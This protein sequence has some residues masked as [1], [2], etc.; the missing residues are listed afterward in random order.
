MD[1]SLL[2]TKF[3]VPILSLGMVTRTGLLERL[4]D[5]VNYRLILVSA[6][7]GFGK[8]TLLSEWIHQI[9]PTI[10]VAWVSLDEGDNEPLRFW[11]YFIT[12]IN[13]IE[14]AVGET[15]LAFLHS[16]Q[17][18]SFES[19]LT[20]L[21]NDLTSIPGD[22]VLVLDDFHF[23]QS[24]AIHK[25]L[26]YFLEHMPPGMRLIISTRADPPLPI[27]RFRGKGTLLEIG[28]DDLRF[29]REETASLFVEMGIKPLSDLVIDAMNTKA[30]GWVAGLKMA[31]L[32]MRNKD[33]L[34]TFV[35]DFTGSQ[36]FITDY[37]FEEVLQQQSEEVCT[38]LLQTSILNRLSFPLCDAI[39]GRDDSEGMLSRLDNSNLF[40]IPLDDS[41]EWYR[42]HHLFR[43]LLQHQLM[44]GTKKEQIKN[45]H[46]KASR[47][48][49]DNNL[50]DDAI[51][52]ALAA[53]DWERAM[54]LI[55][56]PEVQARTTRSQVMLNWL[57]QIPVEVARTRA[58][59]CMNY[60][61]VLEGAGKYD[62]A[63]RWVTH[64]DEIAENDSY[65]Q[66][67]VAVARSVITYHK[68]DFIQAQEYAEK[69]LSLLTIDDTQK[70]MASA[71]LAGV[72]LSQQRYLEAEPLEKRFYEIFRQ[73]GYTVHAIGPLFWL[74]Y[75]AFL[76]GNFQ[77][78]V[79]NFQEVIEL[80]SEFPAMGN[81]ISNAYLMIGCAHYIWNN[82]GKAAYF[83]EKAIEVYQL[84][85]EY[86]SLNFDSVY[87]HLAVTRMAMGEIDKAMEAMEKADQLLN[88]QDSIHRARNTAFH[89]AIALS[90]GDTDSASR[91]IDALMDLV[92]FIPLDAP[93]STMHLIDIRKGKDAA[94]K[95]LDDKYNFYLSQDCK[96]V[97]VG[98]RIRQALISDKYEETLE[99]LS[100]ALAM[101][102]KEQNIR[103]F[104]VFGQALAPLLRRAI[105]KDLEPVYTRKLLDII[106]E[107]EHQRKTRQSE[108]LPSIS[109]QGILSKRET[110]VL[111]LIAEG[112]SNQEIAD[113]LFITLGTAKTHAR[114]VFD[115]LG[116]NDRRRAIAKASDLNLI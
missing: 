23:I 111:R 99:C 77:Q 108:I 80:A 84:S 29:S 73:M 5:C 17:Q 76:R 32:S 95:E 109:T 12:A 82:L 63:E 39:C 18:I 79:D 85:D 96:A 8:T 21:L 98:I 83:Q 86:G 9:Q 13:D 61:Y 72:Y 67:C 27:S 56:E 26:T 75:I 49:E 68:L 92:D 69:A 2:K 44:K 35:S 100:D 106:V 51:N 116:V 38:F 3:Y 40:I 112:L 11:D 54:D 25:D 113:R 74:G 55:S 97:L 90:Q 57:G 16:G 104:V 22:F 42:Y 15:A 71:V 58:R 115:K 81:R 52:H 64:L 62:D 65:L 94:R 105:S 20:T 41:R 30:E 107:E 31:A 87:L 45:L 88:S 70:G 59:I 28:A 50:L 46:R 7:A 14:P 66:G 1:T 37:L 89:A 4:Q 36:R 53:E 114:H 10:H 34:D 33:D 24:P 19:I 47:W 101:G 60:V 43:D 103:H 93:A 78:A 110:E 6:P 91:W 102:E 48:F